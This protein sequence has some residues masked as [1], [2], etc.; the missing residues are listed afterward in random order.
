VR[1]FKKQKQ[2]EETT[3][4]LPAVR[5]NQQVAPQQPRRF[6]EDPQTGQLIEVQSMPPQQPY[7]QV[8]AY[9][10]HPGT[11]GP[12]APMQT[13]NAQQATAFQGSIGIQYNE[14]GSETFMM[15]GHIRHRKNYP[16]EGNSNGTSNYD[17]ARDGIS[18]KRLILGGLMA[19]LLLMVMADV[20]GVPHFRSEP[21]VYVSVE[22]KKHVADQNAPIVIL[23][24]LDRSVFGYGFQAIGWVFSV[25]GGDPPEAP[26]SNELNLD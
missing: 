17:G 14:D 22:G 21:G 26:D 23:K 5:S 16:K 19:V 11:V 4:N 15:D 13:N 1:P 18:K 12:P 9:P 2:D 7:P 8:P 10:T 20:F 25:V 3:P 6:M 24:R